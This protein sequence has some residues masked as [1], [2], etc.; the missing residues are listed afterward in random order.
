MGCQWNVSVGRINWVTDLADWRKKAGE[1]LVLCRFCFRAYRLPD[2]WRVRGPDTEI[3]EE[4]LPDSS[5]D[6]ASS[7]SDSSSGAESD[8]ALVPP[9]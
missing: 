7:S 5:D 1:S 4:Q 3:E 9:A 8:D 2:D 6:S